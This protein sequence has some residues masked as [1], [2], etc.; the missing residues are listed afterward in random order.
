MKNTQKGRSMVEILCVLAIVGVLSVGGIAGYNV[1]INHY[2]ANKI[3]NMAS[4]LAVIAQTVHGTSGGCLTVSSTG[5]VVVPAEGACE[6]ASDSGMNWQTTAGITSFYANGTTANGRVVVTLN[7]VPTD[8]VAAT[9]RSTV[10]NSIIYN[11]DDVITII[12]N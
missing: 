5:Q 7:A 3:L 11:G 1:A 8:S 4:K 9:M 2:R 6:S 12:T 10:G